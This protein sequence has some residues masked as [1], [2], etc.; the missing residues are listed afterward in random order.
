[1]YNLQNTIIEQWY[2]PKVWGFA[3]WPASQVFA[4]LV[5]LRK[6]CY[7]KKIFKSYRAKV[8]VVIVGNL[9]VGGT[10]K[11]P[12]VIAFAQILQ[13]M[14]LRPGIVLRGYK[15]HAA[16]AICVHKNM[17]AKLVGDEAVLLAKRGNWPVVVSKKRVLGVQKLLKEHPVDIVLC[18]DGLQHYALERDLEVVVIDGERG[19]GNGH[20]LPQGPMRELPE[21]LQSVDLKVTNGIDMHITVDKVYSLLNKREINL[22]DFRGKTVHAIAGIGAPS[23]FFKLLATHGITVLEHAFLDHH[24][25]KM[26]DI[27]FTDR[28]PILMT[29]KDAVKCQSFASERC[30]V[31]AVKTELDTKIQDE[32]VRLVQGVLNAGR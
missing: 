28:L 10:G 32:F 30:W 20:C 15:S 29:E 22:Q 25:F 4:G 5:K 13:S 23:K 19:F 14:G 24:D 9:T 8:P 1:M 21:R 2:K 17:D 7:E 27:N 12:L 16:G 26:S 3:L 31:V 18:D 11:T 6:L